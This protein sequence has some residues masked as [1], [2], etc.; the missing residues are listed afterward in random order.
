[1]SRR[2]CFDIMSVMETDEIRQLIQWLQE[3]VT[4]A[5]G[6]ELKISFTEPT[7]DDFSA[8]GFDAEVVTIT[9]G[10]Q[11]WSEMVKDIVETPEYAEP[12]ESAEQV[13]SYAKDV[14]SEYVRKRLYT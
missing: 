10:S 11:W 13:L 6:D 12:D 2:R 3:L 5:T 14:V 7:A 8:K 1:M 9:L 4:L